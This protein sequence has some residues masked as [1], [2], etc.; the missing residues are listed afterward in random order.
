MTFWM[1]SSCTVCGGIFASYR[2]I[3][4]IKRHWS[5][6]LTTVLKL[7]GMCVTAADRQ[8]I[9]FSLQYL[10]IILFDETDKHPL[11]LLLQLGVMPYPCPLSESKLCDLV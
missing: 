7:L 10:F 1:T 9:Y 2:G 3:H 6:T 8:N 11:G 4:S 5:T